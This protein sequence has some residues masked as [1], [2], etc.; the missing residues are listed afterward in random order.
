MPRRSSSKSSPSYR[1]PAT[2]RSTFLDLPAGVVFDDDKYTSNDVPR[3]VMYPRST[4]YY[5]PGVSYLSTYGLAFSQPLG[6]TYGPAL[7][8]ASMPMGPPKGPPSARGA[9][10]KKALE[11]TTSYGRKATATAAGLAAL[12]AL[13][14]AARST[15]ETAARADDAAKAAKAANAA[16][17]REARARAAEARAKAEK[18]EAEARANAEKLAA[19]QR[20]EQKRA[21]KE[22]FDRLGRGEPA[23]PSA[24]GIGGPLRQVSSP[25]EAAAPRQPLFYPPGV[26]P[27][28]GS[29]Q[30]P[31]QVA[32]G[33]TRKRRSPARRASPRRAR[34]ASPRRRSP[35]SSARRRR[36]PRSSPYSRRR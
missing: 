12:A 14:A 22:M 34:R 35:S 20:S 6:S 7:A 3:G 26:A 10:S 25:F 13:T 31:L 30:V 32:G 18:L 4:T 21:E 16:E 27:P 15:G 29:A 36:S 8:A 28:I 23:I 24:P 19:Q 11:A 17:E 1:L 5:Q 2:P 33:R 9:V